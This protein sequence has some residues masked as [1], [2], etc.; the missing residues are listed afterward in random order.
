MNESAGNQSWERRA[1][2]V[3]DHGNGEGLGSAA[4]VDGDTAI[5]GI[6]KTSHRGYSSVNI[7]RGIRTN[8]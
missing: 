8:K 6:K 2:A 1:E 5:D 4:G 7:D 3:S